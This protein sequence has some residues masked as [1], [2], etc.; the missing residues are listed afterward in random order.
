MSKIEQVIKYKA[1]G[2][3]FSTEEEAKSHL[4]LKEFELMINKLKDNI[5]ACE[6]I[7]P[8]FRVTHHAFSSDQLNEALGVAKDIEMLVSK[9]RAYQGC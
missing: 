6:F 2:K 4:V 3:E 7:S 9:L 1:D 5:L 8:H